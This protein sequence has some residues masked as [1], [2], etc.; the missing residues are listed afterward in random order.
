M[1][2]III[3]G[4]MG[5]MGQRI[6][7]CA[8]EEGGFAL[9]GAIEATGHPDIGSGI[10]DGAILSSDIEAVL[11]GADVVID[12][13]HHEASPLFAAACARRGK[14]IVI[15]TTGLTEEEMGRLRKCA[16]KI[17]VLVAPNMSLGVNLLFK[18]VPLIARALGDEYDIEIVEAHHKRKK[19]APSGTAL[20]LARKICESTGRQEKEDLVYGRRG[21]TG[22]RPVRQIA[23]HAVR[24]GDIV[25][26]HT[27]IFSAPGERIEV[28]HRAHSR[29]TFA[30][31]ALL[32]AKFIAERT[33]GLYD[34]ADV[35]GLS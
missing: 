11:D 10:V 2:K 30:R 34:M 32:A 27:V 4:F 8:R 13:S 23:I 22:P 12:F 6:W 33:P 17:P 31:G 14:P 7:A 19:D 26:D 29:D 5:R 1:V 18:V 3:C 20:G 28:T 21:E 24:A 25:G 35:L 16:G 15:G 9:A